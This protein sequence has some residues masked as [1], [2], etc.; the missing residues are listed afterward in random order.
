[1]STA[2][3]RTRLS[4]I[5]AALALGCC[6]TASAATLV[7]NFNFDSDASTLNGWTVV[8]NSVLPGALAWYQDPFSPF[9]AQAGVADSFAA[10]SS[11][12]GAGVAD[13]SDWLITPTLTFNNGDTLNFY[14]RTV[15]GAPAA[16]RLEVRFSAV[17]GTD[18]GTDAGSVDDFDTVL[19]TINP[20][21]SPGP[22]SS[23]C[24][25]CYPDVWTSYS[26][27]FSNLAGATDGAIGFRYFVTNGGPAGLNSNY[28]GLDTISITSAVP[29][30][31]SWLMLAFGL[32]ALGVLRARARHSQGSRRQGTHV[33]G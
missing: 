22:L 20:G 7:E 24:P 19:L 18:V 13:I 10:V 31:S 26:Y 29:E 23:A 28:I 27:T 17:G 9:P 3:A 25:D 21:L 6:A 12:S 32:G 15:D 16:D 2:R 30:P 4:S 14:T 8:N 11:L 33:R 1:M 5:L